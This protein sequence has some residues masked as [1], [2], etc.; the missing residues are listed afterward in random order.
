VDATKEERLRFDMWFKRL[1]PLA[2]LLA[3]MLIIGVAC[4]S[5][6]SE[7]TPTATAA[8]TSAATT[9]ATSTPTSTPITGNVTVF[10]ASSLTES[11]KA[12]GQAFTKANPGVTVEFNN[13]ASS[14]LATQIE[15]G[16][17]ADV[18]A[19]ADT[20]QMQRLVD[21]G[22]IEGTPAAFARNL[23]VMVIP[24][25]NPANIASPQDIAKPGIKLVLAGEDVPIGNYARQIIDKLDATYGGGFKDA[26]LDN[27][28]SN[29]AN[30]R[31]VLAKVELGEADVGIVYTTDARVSGDKVRTVAIPDA[32]NVIATYPIAVVKETDV[33]DAAAAFVAFVRSATGQQI[34]EA[35]GFDSAQ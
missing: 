27:L 24:A 31:A 26:A 12:I 5:D 21:G 3:A 33:K 29:E 14:A 25:A 22:H 2:V 23:P 16:A 10:A 18:F 11:F 34:L 17:P 15:Q 13:A 19:S 6:D 32:S 1:S 35:A 30:V 20:A 4:G 28:V 8:T 7:T 9:T